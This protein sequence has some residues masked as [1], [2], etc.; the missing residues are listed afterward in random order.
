M[1]VEHPAR[2]SAPL[3]ALVLLGAAAA[4]CPE[5]IDQLCPTGTHQEGTFSTTITVRNDGKDCRVVRTADA[6]SADASLFIS[7]E[8][9]NAAL[10][11]STQAD[12]GPVLWFALAAKLRTSPLGDGGTFVFSADT[13]TFDVPA[14]NSPLTISERIE[15]TLIPS[16]ADASV[17]LGPSGLPSLKGFTGVVYDSV[18][19][20]PAYDG[21]AY[22]CNTPCTTTYDMTATKL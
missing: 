18:D 2:R 20:G 13:P 16:D 6:G 22:L 9:F 19:A 7:T 12:G 14:C 8:T 15:G 1:S 21:G 10:C 3:A 5:T 17:V 4:G 11:S